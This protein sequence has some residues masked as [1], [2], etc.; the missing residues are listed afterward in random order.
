MTTEQWQLYF[1]KQLLATAGKL[2]CDNTPEARGSAKSLI[3][4]MKGA[5]TESAQSSEFEVCG[6]M[7]LQ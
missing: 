7:L 5:F 3:S 4:T 1:T 6:G 2:V